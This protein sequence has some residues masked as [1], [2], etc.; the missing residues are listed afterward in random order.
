MNKKLGEGAFAYYASLGVQRSYEKVA[1]HFDTAKRTVSRAAQREDWASRVIEIDRQ[2]R[3]KLEQDAVNTI[4]ETNERHLKIARFVQGKAIDALKSMPLDTAMNAVR[5]LKA[6]ID[7][8]RVILGEPS[9]RQAV[10]VEEIIR[11]EYSRWLAPASD[12]GAADDELSATGIT[13]SATRMDNAQVSSG[14]A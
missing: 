5:A 11:R 7:I 12:G 14:A 2:A 8:E 1:A 3:Q 6:S 4:E 10:S 9:D 13:G